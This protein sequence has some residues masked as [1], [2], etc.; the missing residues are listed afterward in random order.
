[1]ETYI[2]LRNKQTYIN[3]MMALYN[4][5]HDNGIAYKNVHYYESPKISSNYSMGEKV[6]VN[7]DGKTIQIIDNCQ[8][9]A[10][11]CRWN[12]KHGHI[13][14]DFSKKGL[15]DYVNVCKAIAMLK[16]H[17]VKGRLELSTKRKDLLKKYISNNLSVY[18]RDFMVF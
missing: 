1:M 17:D 18:N 10:K 14:I 13:V 9:Y 8:E 15:K 6:L 4:N 11:S 3:G 5:L 7:C 16:P 12:A 2:Q